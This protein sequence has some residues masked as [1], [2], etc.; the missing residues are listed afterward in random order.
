VF[1]IAMVSRMNIIENQGGFHMKGVTWDRVAKVKLCHMS[2]SVGIS[3]NIIILSLVLL[4]FNSSDSS[5][6]GSLVLLDKLDQGGFHK[7]R[8]ESRTLDWVWDKLVL[9]MQVVTGNTEGREVDSHN[10][11]GFHKER[12]SRGS[13]TCSMEISLIM[14]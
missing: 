14:V 7:R 11:G 4:L 1:L 10:H 8:E 3:P 9:G 5:V 6:L 2:C 12:G 13:S